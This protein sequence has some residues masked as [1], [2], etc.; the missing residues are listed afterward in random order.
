MSKNA[1]PRRRLTRR[2]V[3]KWG[4]LAG[5]SM[6]LPLSYKG[7]KALRIPQALAGDDDIDPRDFVNPPTTPFVTPLPIPPVAREVPPFEPAPFA[8]RFED[9]APQRFF[10][11]VEEEVALQIHPDLPQPT[12]VWRYR[13]V[14]DGAGA[15]ALG[16]TFKVKMG[17]DRRNVVIRMKNRL[18]AEH[19]GFAV[20]CSTVHHHG[21][22]IDSFADGFPEN[23]FDGPSPLPA[24][25]VFVPPGFTGFV[26]PPDFEPPRGFKP[27]HGDVDP[28]PTEFDYCYG[29]QD[30]GW[31]HGTPDANDRGS[32]NWYHDHLFDFTGPNVYRGLA[33]FY[34]IFDELD[35]NDETDVTP[36]ASG[37]Y[38]GRM[39]LRLPS[40]RFDIPLAV[41]DKLFDQDAQLV[42]L[43]GDHDGFLGDTVMVNGAIQP[44]LNVARRKYRFRF[45]NATNARF[46]DFF[47]TND[48]G[49]TFRFDQIAHGGGLLS[50]TLRDTEDVF[51]GMAERTEIVIDFSRFSG[52]TVLF[53]EERL[54][55]EDQRGPDGKFDDLPLLDRGKRVLQFRVQNGD[56]NDPSQVP[57]EL[58]PFD[59]ISAAEV[60]QARRRTFVFDRRR[61]AWAINNELADLS[62]E[63][64]VAQPELNRPEIWKFV[65]KS[66]G[67]WHPIHVHLEFMR[68]LK[69]NGKLPP[70]DE[71]DGFARD[72]TVVL[73]P[74]DEVEVFFKFRDYP[75]PWVFHC[76]N[77]EH[78]DMRMMA[79]FDLPD[80]F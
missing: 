77:I 24:P 79:R 80:P 70:I 22:H 26:P 71:R 72:D 59:A 56:V 32:T 8:C 58:R 44:F 74:N 28:L 65:N 10:E 57:D 61:G 19:V 46:L 5:G 38:A 29:M 53:L 4:T 13:D 66:G 62:F 64:S 14:N 23:E 27:P 60:G 16:P 6:L 35:G 34:L 78:E 1:S 21:G 20:P 45:L 42:Y 7:T 25:V 18:P 63:G 67:W 36:I 9:N 75:G 37:A 39:P 73:G 69:R 48:S 76:H 68:V 2:Q 31:R 30:P 17:L 40:G 41:T 54:G 11:I 15:S 3:L 43:P 12:S 33:G 55:Q 49:D 51:L 50:E 52:N 47:L